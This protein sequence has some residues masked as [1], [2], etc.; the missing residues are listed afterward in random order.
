MFRSAGVTE[1]CGTRGAEQ[2]QF[3]VLVQKLCF[4]MGLGAA[5]S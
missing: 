4:G 5:F 1:F 2:G 3:R